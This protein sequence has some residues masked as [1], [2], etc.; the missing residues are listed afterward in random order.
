MRAQLFS[1][2]SI[3]S[4]IKAFLF[5]LLKGIRDR[6][7]FVEISFSPFFCFPNVQSHG[8]LNSRRMV[9]YIDFNSRTYCKNRI[10]LVV[11]L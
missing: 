10:N 11:A 3:R 7:N 5:D 8:C 9:Q 1:I 6:D 4:S 2:V